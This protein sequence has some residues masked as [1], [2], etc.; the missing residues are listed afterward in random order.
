MQSVLPWREREKKNAKSEL[1]R[2]TDDRRFSKKRLQA[3]ELK[4]APRKTLFTSPRLFSQL[5]HFTLPPP[6]HSFIHSLPPRK[7]YK[8]QKE[9]QA[10]ILPSS[11]SAPAAAAA[12]PLF[13]PFFS[14]SPSA[15][16]F[17]A[18]RTWS[19][20]PAP[21]AAAAAADS[22]LALMRLVTSCF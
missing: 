13:C 19:R 15:S 17:G 20:P 11:S 16:S 2:S 22:F 9:S 21:C 3:P 6:R 4:P 12:A 7:F 5:L 1:G 18:V 14:F 8:T 10:F